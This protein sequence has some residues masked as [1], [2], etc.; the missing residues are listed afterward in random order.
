MN[1]NII[2]P[3]RLIDHSAENAEMPTSDLVCTKVPI[4]SCGLSY[5]YIL[6]SIILLS[7][8]AACSF[9]HMTNLLNLCIFVLTSS[10]YLLPSLDL[11]KFYSRLQIHCKCYLLHEIL[12]S[13][14]SKFMNA[15]PSLNSPLHSS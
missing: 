8:Q 12:F 4:D 5:F 7:T 13:A 11:L 10:K 2:F 6:T 14:I 3:S 15:L 9:L 1:L